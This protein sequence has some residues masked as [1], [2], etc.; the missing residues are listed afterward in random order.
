MGIVGTS[1]VVFDADLNPLLGKID[2]A[3]RAAAGVGPIGVGSGG[4]GASSLQKD[5]QAMLRYATSLAAAQRAQGDLTGAASTYRTVLAQLTP[6]TIEANHATARLAQTEAQLARE[7]ANAAQRGFGA[8]FTQGLKSGLLGIVGPIAVATAGFTALKGAIDLTEESFKL[9]AALDTTNLS[10]KLQLQNFRDVNQTLQ[11]GRQFADRY[12]I[13]QVENAEAIQASIPLLRQSKASLSDVEGVLSRLAVLKPEQGIS[14][15]AF[16]LAEL[17]GG[18]AR[19]LATRFNVPIAQ[20]TELKNAIKNG[21]DAVQMMDAYLNSVGLD[22]STLDARTQG[23]TGKMNELKVET[24]KFQL[25]LGGQAGGPGLAL[26]E[27]RIQA[28]HGATRLLSGDFVDFGKGITDSIAEGQSGLLSFFNVLQPLAQGVKNLAGYQQLGE[29]A[30]RRSNQ[31][32]LDAVTAGERKSAVDD[33]LRSGIINITGALSQEQQEKLVDKI[34]TA[35]LAQQQAELAAD[36]ARAAQGLLGAGDQALILAQ[37]YGIATDAAQFLINAQ[38]AIGNATALADQRKGE[39]TGTDLSAREFNTFSDL[40]RKGAADRAADAKRDADKAKQ[41]ADRLAELR[42]QGRLTNA[43]NSAAKIKILQAELAKTTDAIERQQLQ[44]QIDQE[45]SSGA[46]RVGHA[47]S[48]AL[49]L[50]NVE[51]NSQLQLAKTQREGL[52]RLRDQQQDFDLHRARNQEDE[53]RKIASL[54]AHGQRGQAAREKEDFAR[55]QQRDREDFNIQRQ[56]T[57]R[58]NAEG[59]GDIEGRADLRQAQIGNRATLRGNVP[60]AA[61]GTAG[62]GTAGAIATSTPRQAAGATLA[63]A[64]VVNLDG[65]AVGTGV[66]PTIQVLVDEDLSISLAAIGVPGSGQPAVGGVG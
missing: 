49:Q 24:E 55:Q 4:S 12:K 46:G 26:L 56:R 59:L 42:L 31:A 53:A 61:G 16:A 48:T 8:Q 38:Q 14:G 19:S 33:G 62:G 18:Q 13:T 37:K 52:E 63:I 7:S 30:Q 60:I 21:G 44:N 54:F 57:L 40:A 50:Q 32:M 17:Q 3:K 10:I 35:E 22:M 66:W 6:N 34:T 1:T 20:A 25:A 39:Q 9:K 41:D 36:S 28:T 45:R 47:Q 65:K 15:A 64:G 23:A 58:N 43:K 29:E 2:Q 27:A 5:E 11:E 51:E